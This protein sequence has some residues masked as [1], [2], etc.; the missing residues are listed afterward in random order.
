MQSGSVSNLYMGNEV[1][2][3]GFKCLLCGMRILG[4]GECVFVQIEGPVQGG[5]R[6]G[7]RKRVFVRFFEISEGLQGIVGV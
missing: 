6:L 2:G 3:V 4:V 1:L 5:M 7:R